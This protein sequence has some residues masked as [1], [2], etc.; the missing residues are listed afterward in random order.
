MLILVVI[1]YPYPGM[2]RSRLY[3][4]FLSRALSFP[5]SAKLCICKLRKKHLRNVLRHCSPEGG[6]SNSSE[7]RSIRMSRQHCHTSSI[8]PSW[9]LPLWQKWCSEYFA[10]ID[11]DSW[12]EGIPITIY[13]SC[14]W[15][16]NSAKCIQML[17]HCHCCGCLL[18]QNALE[19]IHTGWCTEN[20]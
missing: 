2:W 17:V 16:H 15:I 7:I 8:I 5:S 10:G 11:I 9:W 1:C 18:G 13:E 19:Q 3:T 12:K 14:S 6:G 4:S 20:G